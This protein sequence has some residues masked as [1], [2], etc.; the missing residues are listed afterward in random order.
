MGYFWRDIQENLGGQKELSGMGR[1]FPFCH[2]TLNIILFFHHV[3]VPLNNI[4]IRVTRFITYRSQKCGDRGV[5]AV[6]WEI[7]P[8]SQVAREQEIEKRRASTYYYC[9][10]ARAEFTNFMSSTLN[11]YVKRCSGKSKV[12]T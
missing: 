2:I 3:H 5:G 11:G 6:S 4:K 9:K 10:V 8:L 12:G 1:R 7:S